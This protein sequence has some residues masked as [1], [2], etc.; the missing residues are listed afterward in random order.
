MSIGLK[1]MDISSV[2][3]MGRCAIST[4]FFIFCNHFTTFL[5]TYSTTKAF[6]PTAAP[7]W[8][9]PSVVRFTP[10]SYAQPSQLSEFYRYW[11]VSKTR[12]THLHNFLISSHE[13][14]PVASSA[15]HTLGTSDWS[16]PIR[17]RTA[18]AYMTIAIG[19]ITLCGPFSWRDLSITT[20]NTSCWS[21]SGIF[22]N[23]VYT[24]VV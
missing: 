2:S 20:N 19:L 24:D 15:Y 12:T 21:P 17:G 22:E 8:R 23:K 5:L 1:I 7:R 13:P 16:F 9:L 14:V 6:D 4:S 3:S 18:K 10:V 11:V